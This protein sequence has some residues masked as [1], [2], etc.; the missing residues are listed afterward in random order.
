MIDSPRHRAQ[1]PRQFRFKTPR[2]MTAVAS[3]SIAALA[4]A[5]CTNSA[6]AQ[7]VVNTSLSTETAAF[8]NADSVHEI[9]VSAEPDDIT[10]ALKAYAA[11]GTKDWISAEVTIDGTTFKNVGMKLKGNSTLRGA[12]ESS[13][14]ASLPW[15]LRLDKFE[16]NQSYSGRTEFV[17]RT[18]SSES[19]LNEAVALELLGEA[20]LATEHAAAT[21]FSLNGSDAELRLVIDNPS[22][23]LYSEETFDGEGITY[24]AD[25][26]GDYSYRGDA[27]SDYETAFE[28]ES[29][30]DDLT[31]VATFLDFVNNSSDEDF[32]SKLSD[33]LDTGQFATYLAMQDLVSNTDD[34]DGPGNNSFLRYDAATKKMTVVAWDQNLSFGSGPGGMGGGGP[35]GGG[36]GGGPGKM[37]AD[38]L[39][40][41]ML[42]DGLKLA[43]AKKQIEAGTVPDGVELPEQMTL[44]DGTELINVLKDLAKGEMPEGLSFGGGGQRPG[45]NGQGGAPDGTMAPPEQ[46]PADGTKATGDTTQATKD[47]PAGGQNGG[48]SM[49]GKSNPLV[50]RFLADED[51]KAQYEAAKTEL[52]DKLYESGT[53][54]EI[55]DKWTTLLNNEASDLIDSETVSSEADAI[56]S[57]FTS[58]SA[59]SSTP[60]SQQPSTAPKTEEDEATPGASTTSNS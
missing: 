20:G 7:S 2:A 43:D 8:F 13:D 53:A 5:G 42:P 30:A 16:A 4:L 17:I 10:A 31:P 18:N 12:D 50:T 57:H 6:S 44:E 60:S 26:D 56:R 11:D 59:Q 36:N 34:I 28:V 40:T 24:K 49:G 37:D 39:L 19:S 22:D 51:F 3:L 29:G 21:R 32:S 33:Y 54:E 55:L 35:M 1:S 45:M 48:K 41:S 58:D 46:N 25:A 9:S 47:N 14:P 23:E 15:I 52:A 27:A 38:S